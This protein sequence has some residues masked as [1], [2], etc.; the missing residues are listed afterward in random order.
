MTRT[1][2]G[3]C[4]QLSLCA[5]LAISNPKLFRVFVGSRLTKEGTF[6]DALQPPELWKSSLARPLLSCVHIVQSTRCNCSSCPTNRISPILNPR[7][8]SC[9]HG[10]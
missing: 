4:L 6:K 9:L 1:D 5:Y 10:S 8:E 7:S 3:L 2:E